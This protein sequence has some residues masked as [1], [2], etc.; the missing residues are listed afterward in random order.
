V[1]WKTKD[2]AD[3]DNLRVLRIIK[4]IGLAIDSIKINW[5]TC[6][7]RDGRP[8][9]VKRRRWGSELVAIAAN[10]FFRLSRA[11]VHLW[12]NPKSWQRWEVD[13]FHLLYGQGFRAFAEN[14][15]TVCADR[16]PGE[17]LLEHVNLGTLTL[18]QLEA[19]ARE[20]H[21][22][23]DLWC[24]EFGDLWSHS[25]P[26]LDNVLYDETADRARLIDFELIHDKSL[27]AV[28][29]QADDLLVFLQDLLA[30]VS[31][32]QWLPFALC[33]IEAYGRPE[34]VAELRRRLIVPVGMAWLWCKL[35]TH[36][37]RREEVLHRV[38]ALQ[39]A[40]SDKPLPSTLQ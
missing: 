8:M 4:S 35:R 31:A 39:R 1:N 28:E 9:W 14:S 32:E 7:V 27:T 5:T 3:S 19:A 10:L 16:I 36:Y 20:F 29:R 11:P 33:F 25:D 17:S 24:E 18:R 40:L 12:V 6:E 38:E 2:D 23:H 30:R 34:V 26:H 15:R 22:V 13:C 37:L 21:R